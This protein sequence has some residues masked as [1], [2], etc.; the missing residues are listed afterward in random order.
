MKKNRLPYGESGFKVPDNYFGEFEARMMRQVAPLEN[1]VKEQPFKVPE[2]YFEELEAKV[3]ERLENTPGKGKV[4]PLFNRRTWSYIAGVA[5]VLAVFFSSVVLNGPQEL[6]FEDLDMM[7]VENYLLESV[8]QNDPKN[9]P[10]NYDFTASANP[11]IDKEA[12]LDYLNDNIEEPALL[13]N[14]D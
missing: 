5:A 13:L 4:I 14:E 11:N 3:F 8:D 2:H 1:S 6:S 12:L 9:I 10:E 7:A